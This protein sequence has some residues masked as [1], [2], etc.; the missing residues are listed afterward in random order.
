MSHLAYQAY[1]DT[2]RGITLLVDNG[3]QE[4]NLATV[5][6]ANQQT[7]EQFELALKGVDKL[8]SVVKYYFEIQGFITLGQAFVLTDGQHLKTPLLLGAI[9]RTA[10]FDEQFYAPLANLGATYQKQQTEFQVWS[11]TA[12][13]ICVVLYQG[14]QETIHQLTQQANGVW[15]GL[16]FG[17]LELI[18]Y[19]FRITQP[20]RLKETI[21]PY[22][23]ASTANG[24][25]S[26]VV[27]LK[28]TTPIAR[29]PKLKQPTD[30]IIYEVSVRDFTIHA[31]NLGAKRG[32][33]LGLTELDY[34]KEL[35]IT[36]IQLLP[37]FD[38][39]GVDETKPQNSYNWGYNPSQYNLP[40]GSYALDATDPYAR[41]NELKTLINHL[42]EQGFGVIMDVVY[43]HVYD[44]RTFPF[45]AF[46]PNY[47]Y[48][49]DFH[50]MPTNGSG[51][52]NDVATER[53]MVR[54][55][56]LDSVKFWAT[57][58][59]IDG[60]RFDLMGLMD[61]TTLNEIRKLTDEL[62][63]AI[64]LYGEGWN[65][66]TALADAKKATIDN[67]HLLPGIAHFNDTFRDT[68][69][70]STF[71]HW[72]KGLALGNLALNE[73]AQQVL[74][75]SSGRNFGE[76]FKFFNPE[77]SINYVECHDN[78]TFWDRAQISNGDEADEIRQKR[79]LLATAMVIFAQ[80][81]PFLH[82]GQEFFRSKQGV[83]NSYRDND[84]INA[85]N[86]QQ[87]S[88]QHVAIELVKGYIKI[89][90]AH[91]AFRLRTGPLVKKHLQITDHDH[92]AIE[93]ALTAVK[94][95][96]NY[97][98]IRVF[99]NLTTEKLTITKPLTG[100]CVIA[101]EQESGLAPLKRLTNQITLAPLS[102][103][104]IVK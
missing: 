44:R 61:I 36:H 64:L 58:Y 99:F 65:L 15:Q 18:K 26:V 43:N 12:I 46:V 71:D 1:L 40:E 78:H 16:V 73:L 14:N 3:G 74:A 34:L 82:C 79:Q 10:W 87:V 2:N 70:G 45:D 11:P 59:G 62:N 69:K 95:Y 57:E 7:D 51:C 22:G 30:A 85:I 97:D 42:H 83:E 6:L 94:A 91:G 68:I 35:G 103:T 98:E 80:G 23:V 25:Y 13:A 9:T 49:Y 47:F 21:D 28:K 101:N 31:P 67:A 84:D 54:K 39:E 29:G 27:D 37:I 32:K 50:G 38:F 75:G 56:I 104:V 60:F 63:P 102:T 92:A 89:R 41:I 19:R 52:G 48:R 8:K 66:N 24:S 4:V 90:K 81:I 86:W 53:R 33:Y 93:Y 5:C 76:N 20:H 72:E 88:Q 17:D 100:F 77:Q 55:F 96:G